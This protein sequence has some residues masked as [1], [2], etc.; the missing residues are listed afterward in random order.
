MSYR[1][2]TCNRYFRNKN[3]WHSCVE[4]DIEEHLKNKPEQIVDTVNYLLEEVKRF[5]DMEIN[6]IKTSIQFR[7]GATFLSMR[8]KR[9]RCELEFQLPFEVINE[10]LIVKS[11]RIS[12]KRV[13]YVVYIDCIED[14][15]NELLEWLKESYLLI[16]NA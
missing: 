14:I 3:Q 1:C 16:K 8:V 15:D 5:G 2:P 4:I 10:F 9:D 13:W 11:V 12:K 6:P 7:A